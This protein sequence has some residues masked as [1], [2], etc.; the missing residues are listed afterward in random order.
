MAFPPISV[1]PR[2]SLNYVKLYICYFQNIIAMNT[3]QSVELSL[4]LLFEKRG[5]ISL[6]LCLEVENEMNFYF[7]FMIPIHPSIH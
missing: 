6:I 5:F 7:N 2:C 4:H 1:S 3:T